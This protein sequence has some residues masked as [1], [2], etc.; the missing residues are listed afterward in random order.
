MGVSDETLK[1]ALTKL[2][3]YGLVEPFDTSSYSLGS[4]QRLSITHSGRMHYEMALSDSIYV[5]QMA[6]ASP[7]RAPSVVD[8]LRD[9]KRGKMGVP[10][11]NEVRRV[12]ILY[13]LAQ[14]RTFARIPRDDIYN[15]QARLSSIP[16]F[17]PRQKPAEQLAADQH[18]GEPPHQ[19]QQPMLR[20]VRDQF[21]EHAPLA[22]QRV[23]DIMEQPPLTLRI[24]PL[25]Q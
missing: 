11:W 8:R 12:F 5:G 17:R 16:S 25:P 10:E 1:D 19:R 2:L 7:L 24:P 22:E 4:E 9:L 23:R 20:H 3:N 18:F 13:C 15:G 6:F 21:V 14:D